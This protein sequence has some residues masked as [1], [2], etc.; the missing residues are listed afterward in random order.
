MF[1]THCGHPN[2]D[3]AHFCSKCGEALQADTT[4]TLQPVEVDD[5]TVEDVAEIQRDLRPGQAL[6]V[7]RRGPNAGSS[8]LMEEDTDAMSIG[9]EPS[10]DL[11]LDDV[12]VSRK[13]AQVRRHG[14]GFSV[15]DL[16]SLNGTY[17]NRERVEETMLALGDEIQVG[18]FR[19]L[20]VSG[21]VV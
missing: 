12:T 11:F 21:E 6:L 10:S 15:H 3:G 1:C 16:Q 2:K 4:L 9:R 14:R 7:V 5:E 17:V 19:L 8:F 13:H 20:F 18:K